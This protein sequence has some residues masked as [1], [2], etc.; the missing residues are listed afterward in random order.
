[1]LHKRPK[2]SYERGQFIRACFVTD[3]VCSAVRCVIKLCFTEQTVVDLIS[4]HG[5]KQLITGNST[6]FYK[7]MAYCHTIEQSVGH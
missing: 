6:V 4:S 2:A 5:E 1:M 3:S 7:Q